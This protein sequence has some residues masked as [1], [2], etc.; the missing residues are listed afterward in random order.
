MKRSMHTW[1]RM[2]VI[3]FGIHLTGDAS[4]PLTD[5]EKDTFCH[6]LFIFSFIR[7]GMLASDVLS[8]YI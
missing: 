7:H 4:A 1:H 8:T 3:H 2:S 5:P 6:C